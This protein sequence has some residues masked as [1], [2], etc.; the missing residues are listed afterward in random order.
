M[1]THGEASLTFPLNSLL[2]A[3]TQKKTSLYLFTN[4]AVFLYEELRDLL[5]SV[6]SPEAR[7][8]IPLH[9]T[10]AT[11]LYFHQC[12]AANPPESSR[13]PPPPSTSFPFPVAL[14]LRL[15]RAFLLYA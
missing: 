10:A 2:D 15:P 5:D 12:H 7:K 3:A 4:S 6:F 14:P 11:A 1:G 8:I 9:V 13:P